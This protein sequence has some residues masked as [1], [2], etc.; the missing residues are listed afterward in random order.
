[1]KTLKHLVKLSLVVLLLTGLNACKKKDADAVTPE[2]IGT[3][4]YTFGGK[5]I[6]TN[7]GDY[8]LADGNAYVYIYGEA[9]TDIVQLR[10]NQVSAFPVGT[11]NYL[12]PSN[13]N[14]NPKYNFSGG[15]VINA[16]NPGS[17]A[18]S[19]GVISLTKNGDSYTVN[20]DCTIANNG[21]NLK[22]SYT[23]KFIS[24]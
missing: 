24:R 9:A 1:M 11:Y 6:N 16:A 14:F 5:T 12:S 23:G 8:L 7:R 13:P 20:F 3:G 15:S 4:S 19:T 21:G 22:G 2:A 18:I 17:L 10:V